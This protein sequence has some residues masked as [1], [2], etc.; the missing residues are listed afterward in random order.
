MTPSD[1]TQIRVFLSYARADDDKDYDDASKSFMRRLYRFLDA[2]GLDV[3]WDRVSLPSRGEVFTKEIE[4]AIRPCDRFVLVVGPGAVKSDYVRAEW[5]FALSLCKPITVI[6]RAGDYNIIPGDVTGFSGVNAIDCRPSRD[7]NLSLFDL[8]KRLNEDAPIGQTYGVKSLPKAHITREGVY[9]A[10]FDALKADAIQTTVISAPEKKTLDPS[11]VAVYGM[12]G[13]GKSTLAA[14][15]AHDCHIRRH[16]YDGV[17]WLEVGQTPTVT[18]LQAA[19]G[20]H[21]GDDRQNYTDENGVIRLSALL[22]TKRA[23]VVLDD[24]WDPKIVAKFPVHGTGCRLLITTRSGKLARDVQGADIKLNALTPDEGARLIAE[25]T[26]GDPSDPDSR[27]ITDFLDGY[28]LAVAL[29]A[30]QIA[31][32]YADS[33]ADMLRLLKKRAE[34]EPFKDLAVDEKD[35]DQN[36]ALSLS[37]SYDALTDDLRRR[38]RA[39]GVFALDGTFDRAA[40]AGL[41]GDADEDDARAPLK[42]L[43]GAGLLEPSEQTGRYSQHRVLSAYARALL[44]EAGELDDAQ[45]RHFAFY[46][47]FH[48]EGRDNT[49]A[50]YLLS[51]TPDLENLRESLMWGFVHDPERACDLL[52]RLDNYYRNY[53]TITYRSL[54]EAALTAAECIRYQQGQANTLFGLGG[55]ALREADLTAA[56]EAYGRALTMFEAIGHRLGQANT[57][58]ALGDLALREA[59]LA[60]ARE[61]YGRALP[62]YEGIGARLGQANT[63]RRLGDLALDETDWAAAREAYG[64]AMP[65]YEAIGN[66]LGQANT[67]LAL[68]DLAV[69]EDDLAAAR[70]AYGRTLPMYKAIDFRLGQANTLLALGDLALREADLVAA[71]E[72]YGRALTIYEGIGARLGQANTLRALGDLALREADLAGAR[73]F[74]GRALTL[75][76]S[77]GDRVG[78]MNTYVNMG[79]MYRDSG[80]IPQ[81]KIYFERCLAIA[82]SLPSYHDHPAVQGWRR[83]YQ[84]LTEE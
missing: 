76:E 23:L 45:R 35:K 33:P 72:A 19:L 59:D 16:F 71:G 52:N 58:Q 75:Y 28:T 40:L 55:L 69:R 79:R 84:S 43:E 2:A 5:R 10:A 67:L 39:L 65:I 47:R 24:V 36:L 56:R 57:L 31:G 20:E 21:F 53:H 70:A 13:I 25:R 30:A 8:A 4:D 82:D 46:E 38:F 1:P 81:A 54:L 77:I 73:G 15:L 63:L 17:V 48:S 22:K 60:A 80:D 62:I 68:G 34:T 26:G 66:R 83:A 14:E 27:A 74:Y 61:A 44:T 41:W 6:L 37:L 50:D 51:I 78:L 3:W 7:E 11:A 12:G 18:S 29:S 42:A 64:R 49:D 9:G 32:G